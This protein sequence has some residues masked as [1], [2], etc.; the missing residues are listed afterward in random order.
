MLDPG[1]YHLWHGVTPIPVYLRD[2]DPGGFLVRG[3]ASHVWDRAGRR[4]LDARSAMWNVT[5]GYSCEPVKAA[6]RRQLDVLPSGT[7]LRFE[8][9]PE[10]AVTAAAVLARSLPEPLNYVRFGNT[11]TQMTESAAMLSRFYR[12]MTGEVG[13]DH[14]IALHGSYHGSGPLATALS[15]EPFMHDYCAPLDGYV[16]HIDRPAAGSCGVSAA[17]GWPSGRESTADPAAPCDGSCTAPLLARIDEIGAE[18]VTALI[19]EP[20]LGTYV[21]SLSAHYLHRVAM[22]CRARGIHVIADEV[23]TGCGRAGGLT[24]CQRIGLV[25]DMIVLGK[26]ISAGYFPLAALAVSQPLY[27]TLA[28]TGHPLTFPN[29]STTDGHPVGM[30]AAL[31]T[32]EILTGEGFLAGVRRAGA[33]LKDLIVQAALPGVGGVYGEGLMLGLDLVHDDGTPWS[34]R[35]SNDLR[36]ACAENGL[37]TCFSDGILPLLPPLTISHEECGELVDLLG[38]ALRDVAVGRVS[39]Q[40]GVAVGRVSGQEGVAVGRVSGQESVAVG[41]VSGQE[42]TARRRAEGVPA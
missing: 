20:V 22:E 5:L 31:A 40:A 14:V 25:P 10:I 29:G 36:L 13:R 39:G 18:R 30:A 27:A 12:R 1:T 7:I 24:M 41:R 28:A 26:G 4:Y 8:Q 15:G 35:E 32:L 11:G 33:F 21:L 38:R 17:P 34:L 9:P 6:M 37:L 16:Q 23:T 2:A 19:V 3:E 42:S